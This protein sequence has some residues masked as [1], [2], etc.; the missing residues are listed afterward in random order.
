VRAAPDDDHY[1]QDFMKTCVTCGQPI[2]PE[3][4]MRLSQTQQRIF[5]AVRRGGEISPRDLADIVWADDP[6]GGPDNPCALK[7]HV[8]YLNQKLA[9][10]GLVVRAGKGA[11]AVYQIKKRTP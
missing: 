8:F 7:A 11:G 3:D 5:D 1:E 4:G 6:N 10:L 2:I 9:A